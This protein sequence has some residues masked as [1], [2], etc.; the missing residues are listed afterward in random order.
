MADWGSL[1]ATRSAVRGA[2]GW[3]FNTLGKAQEVKIVSL[4]LLALVL[5]ALLAATIYRPANALAAVISLDMLDQWA[6][7]A[8]PFFLSHSY[9]LNLYI[10]ALVTG[11]VCIEFLRGRKTPPSISVAWV[12]VLLLYG[13]TYVS[14]IW[15]PWTPN[16]SE[17]L[18]KA[19]PY[20]VTY[21]LIT[22]LLIRRIDDLEA[23]SRLLLVIGPVILGAIALFGNFGFRGLIVEGSDDETNAMSLA[24]YG[25]LMIMA[26][27]VASWRRRRVWFFLVTLA[28]VFLGIWIVLR[29]QSRAPLMVA[30][31]TLLLLWIQLY[32][33]SLGTRIRA[34]IVGLAVLGLVGFFA[35]EA[36]PSLHERWSGE[37]MSEDLGGRFEMVGELLAA[38]YS[39]PSTILFGLG[40]SASYE[41]AGFYPHMVL[42]EVLGEEGVVGSALFLAAV[43]LSYY[44]FRIQANH[45]KQT[46][47][48]TT[49]FGI[50]FAFFTYTFVMS[51]KQGQLLSAGPLFMYAILGANLSVGVRKAPRAEI[52]GTVRSRG[53]RPD[54]TVV[55]RANQ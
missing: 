54:P 12:I 27:V 14:F 23:P 21:L 5:A 47:V 11:A 31:F 9:V 44:G 52:S 24:T 32:P 19:A 50:L 16:G 40:N 26:Y 34:V 35:L 55:P 15:A 49:A 10:G 18:R 41:V 17:A 45:L 20:L 29:T 6:E 22:P 30:G 39:D 38:W 48:D 42:P 53:G 28:V 37:H 43:A 2:R 36:A 8:H 51:F 46:A 1:F 7:M 13:Y 25:A 3:A 33:G 4:I